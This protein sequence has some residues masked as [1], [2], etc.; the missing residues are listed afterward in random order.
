MNTPSLHLFVYGS[1]R[2][3]FLNPAFD[4]I[5]NHFYFIAHGTVKGALYDLGEYPAA[6]PQGEASIIGELFLAKSEEDFNWAISQLDD[7][8]GLN[9]AEGEV[10]LYKRELVSV[11][12]H[13]AATTAWIYWYN[14]DVS[15]KP[16]I[17]SGDMM[18]YFKLKNG[19]N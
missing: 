12:H 5:K 19:Q 9:P 13:D 6:V 18:E 15:G 11:S 16:F 1:L 10:S 17:E 8:E 14:G 3:G 7:Y 4:Y 2:R